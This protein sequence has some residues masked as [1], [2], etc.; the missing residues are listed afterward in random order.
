MTSEV[1]NLAVVHV[2]LKV[3]RCHFWIGK[4]IKPVVRLQ[5]LVSAAVVADPMQ[6]PPVATLL[7]APETVRLD[8]GG[9]ADR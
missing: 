9:Q 7:V 4:I 5:A 2:T 3:Q 1:I 8:A 6:V